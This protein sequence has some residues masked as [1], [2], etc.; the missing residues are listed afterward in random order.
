[1]VSGDYLHYL[2]RSLDRAV[3]GSP[4]LYPWCSVTVCTICMVVCVVQYMVV[5]NYMHGSQFLS[6]LLIWCCT[7]QCMVV[8]NYI[9][10]NQFLS[11]LLIW[12]CTVQYM[13]VRNYMHG[14]PPV[15]ACTT[16]Y[17][18]TRMAHDRK[19]FGVQKYFVQ[20]SIFFF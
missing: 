7:V 16:I 10:G 13:V 15:T 17:M 1:M 2:Y 11:A 3:Y 12:C 8:R 6:A 4:Q 20:C 5:R 14:G 9:H 18:S 19:I